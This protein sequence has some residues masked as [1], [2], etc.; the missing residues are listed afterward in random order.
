MLTVVTATAVAGTAAAAPP[1][2]EVCTD[3]YQ[4]CL[5]PGGLY[6]CIDDA[7]YC[8]NSVFYPV[9]GKGSYLIRELTGLCGGRP[10]CPI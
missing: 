3:S 7:E 1:Y 2:H 10:D 9:Y 5:N 4:E 8:A 6:S